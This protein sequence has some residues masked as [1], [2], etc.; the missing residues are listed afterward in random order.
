MDMLPASRAATPS[1]Q[2]AVG[3]GWFRAGPGVALERLHQSGS[4]KIRFCRT[5]DNTREAVL[6]N[7]AGGL[8]GGDRFA[9]GVDLVEGARC[10]VVTQ[11]CE[12]VYRAASDDPASVAVRIDLAAGASLEWLPQ[13][14][15]LF[16]GARLERRFDVRLAPG[17]RLLATE[18]VVLGRHA[19]GETAIRARLRDRWRVQWGERLIFADELRL[20]AG[21][22]TAG[23]P[24]L[25][26]DAAAFALVLLI[27]EDAEAVLDAV[28]QV[29][30]D[31]GGAS[32]WDGKLICRI[33]TADAR[34]LRQT[35]MAVMAALRGGA[36]PPRLWTV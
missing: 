34:D 15:I 33:A 11:A 31:N 13:E 3:E 10:R 21:P 32:A 26:R 30:G 6:L 14:T 22:S 36:L 35:L 28:L 7:T 1:P 8:A 27:A 25:L 18:A 20:D 17:A 12:K 2:R 24:A 16:E 23:R 29:L 5:E 19:M 9:W 4:A